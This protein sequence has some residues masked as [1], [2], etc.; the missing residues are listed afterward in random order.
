MLAGLAPGIDWSDAAYPFMGV[1]EG[2]METPDGPIPIRS[3]RLSFSGEQAW[4]VF[5][6][7]DYGPALHRAVAGAV[8]AA[9]GAAA[10]IT[11]H[12]TPTHTTASTFSSAR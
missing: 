3:A 11:P 2:T 12:A 9:G 1:R 4:E 8:A 7:A 10:A 5:T 6:P